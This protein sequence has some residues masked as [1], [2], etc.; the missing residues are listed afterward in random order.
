MQSL[1]V[2]Y[3]TI[4]TKFDYLRPSI[5]VSP[6]T[7]VNFRFIARFLADLDL[8][9]SNNAIFLHTTA[10]FLD[11]EQISSWLEAHDFVFSYHDS[12]S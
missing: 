10:T 4:G 8:S 11:A 1:I 12:A 6:A 9:V 3:N 7:S 5:N 2:D